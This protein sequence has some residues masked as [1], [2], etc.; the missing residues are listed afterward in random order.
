LSLDVLRDGRWTLDAAQQR[1]I[2]AIEK[3]GGSVFV[4]EDRDCKKNR[5][6]IDLS[7]TQATDDELRVHRIAYAFPEL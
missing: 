2:A 4:D 7:V 1:A 6:T 3:L 5:I